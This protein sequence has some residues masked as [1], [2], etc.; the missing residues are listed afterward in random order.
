[1][2]QDRRAAVLLAAE[3]LYSNPASRQ[4]GWRRPAASPVGSARANTPP[5][6]YDRVELA[7]LSRIRPNR[8]RLLIWPKVSADRWSAASRGS[9][10]A[11][12]LSGPSP[13][14]ALQQRDQRAAALPLVQQRREPRRLGQDQ[15]DQGG[16]LR[17]PGWSGASRG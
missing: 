16:P 9:S 7:S 3:R 2:A 1:M 11:S 10:M 14:S 13:V 17:Q 12:P 8:V 6:R 15:P 5:R 4:P